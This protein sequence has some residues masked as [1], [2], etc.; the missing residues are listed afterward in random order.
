M[1]KS[2]LYAACL[3]TGI[4]AACSGGD[5]SQTATGTVDIA[6]AMKNPGEVTTSQFGSKISFV[7]LETNDSVL[8]SNKFSIWTT[9]SKVVLS[10]VGN[11]SFGTED[12]AVMVFDINTGK[13]L[14]NIGQRGQGPEDYQFPIPNVDKHYD[15][16][17]FTAGSGGGRVIYSLD[18][19]YLGKFSP[20]VD[21]AQLN[22]M[23]MLSMTDSVTTMIENNSGDESRMLVIRS[24]DPTGRQIDSCVV[25]EGQPSQAMSLNFSGPVTFYT[26]DEPF[27]YSGHSIATVKDSQKTILFVGISRETVGNEWHIHEEFCDT[28]FA[29]SRDGARPSLIFDFGGK[30]FPFE[31][32]NKRMPSASEM[33]VTQLIEAPDKALFSF[34]E[35]W[36]GDDNHKTY[37]GIFD[38]STGKTIVADAKNGIRDDL[39]GFMPFNPVTTTADGKWIGILTMEQIDEWLDENPEVNRPDWL[40]NSTA[41]DNPVLVII[42][43]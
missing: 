13:F 4:M 9:D 28:V 39:G 20:Q 25:F 31:E 19:K 26:Y 11:I 12:A 15:K 38:R 42:S 43:D 18:G 27:T 21:A 37:I 40:A 34:S 7:P 23:Q 29:I 30:G 1:N 5:G 6:G 17:S 33:Y 14:N 35:G 32:V 36:L 10:N 22:N 8:V 24:F 41:E 2:L 3:C 16:V